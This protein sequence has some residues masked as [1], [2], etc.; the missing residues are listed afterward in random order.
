MRRY[1]QWEHP[2]TTELQAFIEVHKILSP[3]LQRPGD[4]CGQSTYAQYHT[5]APQH[6]SRA[7]QQPECSVKISSLI[8]HVVHSLHNHRISAGKKLLRQQDSFKVQRMASRCRR[9]HRH[10]V[11]SV[12]SSILSFHCDCAFYSPDSSGYLVNPA[13]TRVD[14]FY[15]ALLAISSRVFTVKTRTSALCALCTTGIAY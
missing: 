13:S 1:R 4:S 9:H 11:R 2:T 12:L 5:T 3:P 14:E 15:I 8:L 7:P 6:H 10:D